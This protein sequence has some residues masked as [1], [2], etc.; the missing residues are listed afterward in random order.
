MQ[1]AYLNL[2]DKAEDQPETKSQG[3]CAL[4]EGNE[5]MT[6]P[7]LYAIR[8]PGTEPNSVGWTVRVVWNKFPALSPRD[9]MEGVTLDRKQVGIHESM[10]S[11]GSHEV[12]IASPGHSELVSSMEVE[13]LADVLRALGARYRHLKNDPSHEYVIALH[14]KGREAGESFNHAHF[15]IFAFP[16]VPQE[17]NDELRGAESYFRYK[18]RCVYCDIV[19]YEIRETIRVIELN[20]FFVAICPL[21]ITVPF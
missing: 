1:P 20:E 21:R 2:S 8:K 3:I 13:R 7:E 10:R 15:Q 6:P 18:K 17:I 16:I 12:I 4:C 19:E 11:L 5:Q 9:I 14:N